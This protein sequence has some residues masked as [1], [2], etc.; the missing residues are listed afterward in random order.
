MVGVMVPG[1]L[2]AREVV[3]AAHRPAV[4][5]TRIRHQAWKDKLALVVLLASQHS[6]PSLRFPIVRQRI[7]VFLLQ[8]GVQKQFVACVALSVAWRLRQWPTALQVEHPRPMS[9][10]GGIPV[11]GI[12]NDGC[13][14]QLHLR[15]SVLKG[16]F[17]GT[18]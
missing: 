18:G 12:E 5:S 4:L 9:Q 3:A 16:L 13:L 15:A 11:E 17:V 6:K 14:S 8:E 10:W 2:Q 7:A 1:W